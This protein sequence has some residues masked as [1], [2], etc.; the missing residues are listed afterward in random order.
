MAVSAGLQKYFDKAKKGKKDD[1]RKSLDRI[2]EQVDPEFALSFTSFRTRVLDIVEETPE[3]ESMVLGELGELNTKI[4]NS[5]RRHSLR[6]AAAMI[7]AV[8]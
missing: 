4:Q 5:N 7:D 3:A 2:Y 1:T 8:S 6:K